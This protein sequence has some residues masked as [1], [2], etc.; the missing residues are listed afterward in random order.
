[1]IDFEATLREHLEQRASAIEV[2]PD[3]EAVRD[4]E[5]VSLTATDSRSRHR[6]WLVLAAAAILIGLLAAGALALNRERTMPS[7]QPRDFGRR[8][9]ANGVIVVDRSEAEGLIAVDPDGGG[10]VSRALVRSGEWSP[11]G[12]RLAYV[13]GTT[14]SVFDTTT[15]SAMDIGS[16]DTTSYDW[17]PCSVAWSNDGRTV[18]TTTSSGI[19][20]YDA[21]S[22]SPKPIAS[23]SVDG[24][25]DNLNW[26]ADDRLVFTVRQAAADGS[27]EA[28][29]DT[30]NAD[31]TNQRT[32]AHTRSEG[33]GLA[34]LSLDLS[35]DG[36]TL[37]WL[38]GA[39]DSTNP[40]GQI[41]MKLMMMG[42]DDATPRMV[43]QL[44]HCYCL[45]LAPAVTWSPD[46][47]RLALVLVGGGL[48]N[49]TNGPYVD[50]GLDVGP[51]GGLSVVDADGRNGKYLGP[52][53]GLP[54][55]QPLPP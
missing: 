12:S 42:V 15:S 40:N 10:R 48:K 43:R 35:P 23:M 53:I 18:A 8:P 51:N 21:V 36:R 41:V 32:I 37:V 47:K 46:G 33:L 2:H 45:G 26:T 25:P 52:A 22:P 39:N 49:G 54:T 16:C 6:L 4:G 9:L 28:R 44:G 38:D 34:Y 31:G 20:L 13:V 30:I 50:Q 27:P 5:I 3:I 7:D 19:R 24:A 55:W 17:N 11:D 1:M 14:V 29:I